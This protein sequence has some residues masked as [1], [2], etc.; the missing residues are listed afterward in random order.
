MYGFENDYDLYPATESNVIT[1]FFSNVC[2]K[3]K[4]FGKKIREWAGQ[5]KEKIKYLLKNR[6]DKIAENDEKAGTLSGEIF[7]AV[8]NLLDNC[9]TALDKVKESYQ[10]TAKNLQDS[11]VKFSDK[12]KMLYNDDGNSKSLNGVNDI[13]DFKTGKDVSNENNANYRE[14]HAKAIA[15]CTK[16]LTESTELI[17]ETK[18][19]LTE[20]AH[21]GKVSETALSEAHKKMNGLYQGNEKMAKQWSYIM[22]FKDITTGG[23]KSI[24]GKI[25][26]IY[27]AVRKCTKALMNKLI[28]GKFVSEDDADMTA[29]ERREF[30]KR[31]REYY[32]NLYGKDYNFDKLDIR[33][34]DRYKKAKGSAVNKM[35]FAKYH[36]PKQSADAKESAFDFSDFEDG[37]MDITFD[38]VYDMAYEA[39][40]RDIQAFDAIP[41]ASEEFDDPF[42]M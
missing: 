19:K 33:E 17:A 23:L 32:G 36:T 4:E 28:S 29:K 12:G 22:R 30:T 42:M 39:A 13:N 5:L 7:T 37:S 16:T 25:V 1:E 18:Q 41:D 24:L 3:I 14:K 35:F 21:I 31:K 38:D 6:A 10:E 26:S 2:E 8:T 40:I 34:Q 20:L 15:E 27:D 9:E 11:R